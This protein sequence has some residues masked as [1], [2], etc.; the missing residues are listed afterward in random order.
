LGQHTP[1]GPPPILPPGA[2]IV[3]SAQNSRAPSPVSWT[4]SLAAGQMTAIANAFGDGRREHNHGHLAHSVRVAF[5]M[6]P[7][8]PSSPMSHV[9]SPSGSGRIHSFTGLTAPTHALST[10]LWD[11]R[12]MPA[13]RSGSPPIVLPPLKVP[14]DD[15][16]SVDKDGVRIK[17]EDTDDV[18]ILMDD[19]DKKISGK[20]RKSERVELPGFSQFEAAARGLP[21]VI[22]S[23]STS[24]L[25]KM[26]IDFVR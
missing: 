18:D 12:S 4:S 14:R 23:A 26:S 10:N 20:A 6:T 24:G 19:V 8:V 16:D 2:G 21:P 25:Q 15:E 9:Q 17:N 22:S 13:S 7:I 3:S 5:G 11:L 1:L